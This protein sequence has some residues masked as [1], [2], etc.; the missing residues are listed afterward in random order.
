LQQELLLERLTAKLQT[1]A[2]RAKACNTPAAG[3]VFWPDFEGRLRAIYGDKPMPS[4]VLAERET[5]SW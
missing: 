4:M 1:P 2:C 3:T 5:S